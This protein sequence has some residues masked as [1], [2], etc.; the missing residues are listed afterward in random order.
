MI[1]ILCSEFRSSHGSHVNL[2]SFVFLYF[3]EHSC[4]LSNF[5][6]CIEF[7]TNNDVFIAEP[8]AAVAVWAVL[9]LFDRDQV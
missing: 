2:S 7:C 6:N 1:V 9:N 4:K 8:P 5:F 3:A